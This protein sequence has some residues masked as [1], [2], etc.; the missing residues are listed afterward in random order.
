MHILP[1]IRK[2]FVGRA[3]LKNSNDYPIKTNAVYSLT[4]VLL[5]LVNVL[6]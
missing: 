6:K 4:E 1:F 3:L 2:R 5:M